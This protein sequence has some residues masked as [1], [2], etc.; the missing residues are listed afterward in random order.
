MR[1]SRESARRH[2]AVAT[3][4]TSAA[5]LLG[6]HAVTAAPVP[7]VTLT[8]GTPSGGIS[9]GSVGF[10]QFT[11]RGWDFTVAEPVT[12]TAL[13]LFDGNDDWNLFPPNNNLFPPDGFDLPHNVGLWDAGGNLLGSVSLAAGESG[14]LQNFFRF[15]DLPAPVALGTTGTYRVA[16]SYP[17][18]SFDPEAV[19]NPN[20]GP[21]TTAPGITPG[22]NYFTIATGSNGLVR[23]T[24]PIP[25]FGATLG[26][27]FLF[28]PGVGGVP[29]G[30][31]SGASVV[32]DAVTAS[33]LPPGVEATDLGAEHGLDA[34]AVAGTP[35]QEKSNTL[36]R[37]FVLQAEG[38]DPVDVRIHGG[39]E[40]R[41]LA[42]R[43]GLASVSVGLDLYEF[44]GGVIGSLLGRDDRFFAADSGGGEFVEGN[45]FETLEI[46]ALLTPG[47]SYLIR[48]Q[49][50]VVADGR[51]P[52]GGARAFFADTFEYAI[53]GE[54]D[55]PFANPLRS[56]IFSIVQVPEP[57]TLGLGLLAITALVVHGR[58]RK[59]A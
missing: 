55:N 5:V 6:S 38:S 41:L 25:L 11:M 47:E 21:R 18:D 22:A 51:G 9:G 44:T 12:V 57:G 16:A 39:L 58:R 42:D 26:P 30:G 49:L 4:L 37:S 1:Q 31:G 14:T 40:G 45:I 15:A 34:Q 10:D 29:I 19:L 33:E 46:A 28:E 59:R 43:G 3:L 36:E 23:P 56:T 35:R 27:N 32:L 2:A 7:A 20:F 48:S 54:P 52:A 8:G 17:R 53:S 24:T 50:R 13:G